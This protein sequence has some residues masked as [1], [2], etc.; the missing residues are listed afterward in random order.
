MRFL[1]FGRTAPAAKVPVSSRP[2]PTDLETLGQE[3]AKL[4]SGLGLFRLVHLVDA[5][6][7]SPSVRTVLSVGS[8]LGFHEEWIA[9]TFPN[10]QVVGV[11]RRAPSI[12]A[13]A[14]N[15]RFL[16]GDLLDRSFRAS[17]PRADFVFSIECLEHIEDDR[18][19][20]A[21]M[22]ECVRPGGALYIQV[23]FANEAEQADPALC[24]HERE[25]FE[26]VRPGY[27]GRTLRR[28]VEEDGF[29]TELVAGAFW[30]PL[31]PLVWAASEKLGS[32]A[33]APHWKSLLTLI[34]TDVKDGLP[35]NRTEATAIKILARRLG[36]SPA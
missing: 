27:D 14:P 15:L 10:W 21:G 30:F 12:T 20:L 3:L 2:I 18:S 6:R 19:V 13:P 32:Q 28:M 35:A 22:A 34:E 16:L 11:D 1:R 24:K 8:G 4:D 23:P 5:L 33:L 7:R 31:Q 26:H 25:H 29:R 17:L 9:R 36:R